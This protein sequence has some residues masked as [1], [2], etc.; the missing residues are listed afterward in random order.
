METPKY[1][2]RSQASGSIASS[3]PVSM[4]FYYFESG[5]GRSEIF[6]TTQEQCSFLKREYNIDLTFLS[7]TAYQE[8]LN[9]LK[10]KDLKHRITESSGDSG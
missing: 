1:R 7:R 3:K 2:E 4:L 5:P 9:G 10:Q 8:K 6:C